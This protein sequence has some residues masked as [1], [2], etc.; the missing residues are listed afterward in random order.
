MILYPHQDE[1]IFRLRESLQINQS[2]LLQ[3]ATGFGKTAC[4]SYM[5]SG[6]NDKKLVA[7]FICHRKELVEQTSKTLDRINLRHGFI[8]AGRP[9]NQLENIFIASVDTLKNRLDRLQP[10]DLMIFDGCHHC[11]AAGWK[12]VHTWA[13]KGG[14]KIVGLSATPWRL[15]GSGLIDFFQDMVKSPPV[16][17]LIENGFLSAYKAFAPSTPDLSK[18]KSRM[19]D[20]N[21]EQI[22]Q[23]MDNSVLFG[24]AVENWKQ[25]AQGKKNDRLCP[26]RRTQ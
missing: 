5:L 1:A 19:G 3:A 7:W 23:V 18:V 17:W 15:D 21:Q 16:S 9:Y 24:C 26:Q 22:A 2:V 8:A 12:A 4:A 6:A 11:A 14:A 10:P 13:K 20:Y 25:R